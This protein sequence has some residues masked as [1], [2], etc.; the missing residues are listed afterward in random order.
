MVNEQTCCARDDDLLRSLTGS[1][2]VRESLAEFRRLTGLAA[3]L[4]P[5][6]I[7]DQE[8]PFGSEQNEF[9]RRVSSLPGGCPAC[10]RVQGK[11][12]RRVGAKLEPQRAGCP[13]GMI[14][15]AVPVMMAGHHGATVIG[16]KVLS[17]P[18]NEAGFERVSRPLRH[19][20]TEDQLGELREAY[21]RAPVLSPEQLDAALRLLHLLAQLF[22]GA[23]AHQPTP[24][25][26]SEPPCIAEA[27]QLVR[28][29]LNERVSTRQTAGALH[30][31]ESYFCRLFHRVTG[32]TFHE[33]VA[34]VRVE[35][36]KA[37]LLNSSR[38]VGDVAFAA[39]FQ[40]LSGFNHV[41][42]AKTGM[43]PSQFRRTGQTPANTDKERR[44][45]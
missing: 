44:P 10:H 20:I 12:L 9:C 21:F 4:V 13:A 42:K 7:P 36:A 41:F 25:S 28:L 1:A 45:K 38:S 35:H 27:K 39:G 15:F 16:G 24:C 8:I 37:L 30:L 6:A 26:D 17:S 2:L 18:A 29:H 11:L 23:I 43:T 3:K 33:Y 14:H 5:A 31:T 22:V 19:R 40:T 32:M 34:E